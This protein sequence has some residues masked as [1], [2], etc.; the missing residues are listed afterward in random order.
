MY[1]RHT[2]S[3]GLRILTYQMPFVH[4]ASVLLFFRVGSRYESADIAGISHLIEHMI[5][6]G[7]ESYPTA[8][9]I[10]EAIE[11]VGGVLDAATDKELTIFSAKT[12]D[13]H[14]ELALQ[15]LS[16]MV[17]HPILS[18]EELEKERRVII[19][20]LSMYHDSPQD[21]VSVLADETV[22]PGLPL[23]REVAGT[24]ESIASISPEAIRNYLSEYYVPNNLIISVAGNIEHNWVVATVQDLFGAWQPQP[25]P[26]WQACPQP[27]GVNRVQIEYR[28]TEQTNLCLLTPGV[29]HSSSDYYP[30]ILLNAILGD[31]MSSRLFVEVREHQGL[32]YDVSTSPV[33]YYDT[34]IFVVYA[35]VEPKRTD[36]ALRAILGE[37]SRIRGSEVTMRDLTRAQDYTKGRMALRLEDTHSIASWLG[38]QEALL[39][40][41]Y[42]L[43]DIFARIDAVTQQDLVHLAT[44]LFQDDWLRLAIIGPHKSAAQFDAMLHL[45]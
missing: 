7:S 37:L 44:R 36:A 15:L 20:E 17:Q 43:E 31:G 30:L 6:K 11:G 12:A 24:R 23:G 9:A 3:N 35:G 8:Q 18:E 29:P 38:G 2:L 19:E 39:D 41:I 42:S 32:A 45:D 14:C 4:S 5:F 10:S 21:W 27:A 28:R 25:V 22:W 33:S 34:G 13:R 1:Q 40:E 16:D 26:R